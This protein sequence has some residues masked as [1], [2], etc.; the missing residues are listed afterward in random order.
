MIIIIDM[1]RI[2]LIFD[3]YFIVNSLKCLVTQHRSTID[4][5]T[6]EIVHDNGT[7]WHWWPT[8]ELH[9]AKLVDCVDSWANCDSYHPDPGS[10]PL[11][12]LFGNESTTI[13]TP[14]PNKCI[15]CGKTT[16]Q[17]VVDGLEVGEMFVQ[18][19]CYGSE[20]SRA[21]ADDAKSYKC[22]YRPS[23]LS[24]DSGDRS[25]AVGSVSS[26]CYCKDDGCNNSS[27]LS[28]KKTFMIVMFLLG[29]IF[30]T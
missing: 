27:K 6:D 1:L 30:S 18:L 28:I 12:N 20:E 19:G 9:R 5:L 13:T 17:R 26:A 22:I 7:D 23:H 24:P 25:A 14:T 2:I 29:S 3:Y 21:V 8:S 4:S 10:N 11:F 15:A 16:W